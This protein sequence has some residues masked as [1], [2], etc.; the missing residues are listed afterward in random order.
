MSD[1]VKHIADD[2]FSGRQRT[3]AHALCVQHSPT[4]AALSSSFLLNHIC[5]PTARAERI[6][7]KTYGVIQQR[8]YE[9]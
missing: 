5:L 6:D 2:I 9:S 1:A 8:E 3:G 4:A 7:Y